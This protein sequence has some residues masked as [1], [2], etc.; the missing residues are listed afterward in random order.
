MKLSQI[1]FDKNKKSI[2]IK[3]LLLNQITKHKNDLLSLLRSLKEEGKTVIGYGAST[4]GNVLLQYCGITKNEIAFISEVNSDKFNCVTPG[5]NI[6]II[7]EK[8]ARE[9][10]PDYFLVLPW[11]FKSNILLREKDFI[12]KG[13]KFIFPLPKIQIV[14]KI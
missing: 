4:K 11:H 3:K 10:N 5:S 2:K 8:E 14:S 6:P 9:L 13:G 12:S 1:I 7:S